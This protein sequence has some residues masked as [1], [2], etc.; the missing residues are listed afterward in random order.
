MTDVTEIKQEDIHA[1]YEAV[2]LCQEGEIVLADLVRHF[3]FAT[4]ST[5]VPGDPSY[6]AY[7]EGQ[8][9]VMVHVM[10]ILEGYYNK[11]KE[12]ANVR[13]GDF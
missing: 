12:I 13:T 3:G 1:A 4:K 5:L 8:R 9:T 2:F 6:S 7:H 10:K 11:Q